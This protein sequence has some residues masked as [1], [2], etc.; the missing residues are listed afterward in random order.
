MKIKV[1]EFIKQIEDGDFQ[2]E[3]LPAIA[4]K[5]ATEFA[6]KQ[7]QPLFA[8]FKKAVSAGKT[9]Q[10]EQPVSLGTEQASLMLE[11][12]IINLPFANTKSVDNFFEL[13]DEVEEITNLIVVS[14]NVNASGLRIDSFGTT[15]AFLDD[16]VAEQK[17]TANILRELA[18]IE[19]NVKNN[20]D[21]KE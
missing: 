1:A 20:L 19:E 15:T 3:V 2:K 21:T 5:S 6:A 8:A 7:L 14:A 10:V 16:T 17:V 18:L 11:S 12:G 9:V 4:C 13:D